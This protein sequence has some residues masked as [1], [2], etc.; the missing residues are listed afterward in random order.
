MVALVAYPNNDRR[1]IFMEETLDRN[2]VAKER[3]VTEG[4]PSVEGASLGT[5]TLTRRSF[6]GRTSAAAAALMLSSLAWGSLSGCAKSAR[7]RAPQRA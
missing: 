2:E 1:V 7:P 6:V 4:V 5:P 3:A